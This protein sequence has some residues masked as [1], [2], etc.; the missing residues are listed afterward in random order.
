[1]PRA[2]AHKSSIVDAMDMATLQAGDVE[3]FAMSLKLAFCT[4]L[5]LLVI[6]TPLSLW[7]ALSRAPLVPIV[8]AMVSMPLVLPPTVLGFYLLLWFS[9]NGMIGQLFERLGT[10][11]P[12]FSFTGLWLACVVVSLPFVVQPLQT[13]FSSIGRRPWE[14][15]ATL[16]CSPLKSFVRVIV[17]MARR[18]YL[19]AFTLA[20]AHTLGEF[21][22]VLMVGGNI[23]GATQTISTTI[24][25]HVE[26]L[27]YASAHRLSALLVVCGVVMVTIVQLASRRSREARQE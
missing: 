15:A 14:V 1:M 3:A 25:G 12:A 22:V 9:P 26:A 13:A 18:G 20:F 24:F 2:L 7:L 11:A 23:R 19:A 6:G 5:T 17:P 10:H 21:G 27:D 8:H 16:R 4:S